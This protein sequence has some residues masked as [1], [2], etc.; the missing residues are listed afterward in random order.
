[1]SAAWPVINWLIVLPIVF[2]AIAAP[3]LPIADPL[4]TNPAQSLQAPSAEHLLGTDKIGRDLLAR[5]AQQHDVDWKLFASSGWLGLEAPEELD[6]AGATFGD[7]SR[8][9]TSSDV[10]TATVYASTFANDPRKSVI[11][12]VN[13][14]TT[15]QTAG[16]NVTSSGS[17]YTSA[18]VYTITGAGGPNVVRQGDIATVASNAYR[19]TMPPMSVSV[20]VP[21]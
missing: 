20:I 4:A 12:A 5:S 21:Q 2:V 16:V 13:K 19:Y 18:R 7:V 8:D 9:A 3:I 1:M 6:G 14:A 11:V 17:A 10:A 15:S